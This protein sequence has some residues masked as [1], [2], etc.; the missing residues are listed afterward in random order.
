V[1]PAK[2]TEKK[3]NLKLPVPKPV[4]VQ[5]FQTAIEEDDEKLPDA[6]P[7]AS[8]GSDDEAT[9]KDAKKLKQEAPT[10]K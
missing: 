3:P 6:V 10:P 8:E 7:D 2:N 1:E 5:Y 9:E 4:E